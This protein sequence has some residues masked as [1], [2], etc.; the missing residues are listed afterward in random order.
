MLTPSG[1]DCSLYYEDFARGVGKQECRARQTS[2][3]AEWR[4]ADCARCPVPE[5][6]MANGSRHLELQLVIH[7]GVLGIGRRVGVEA[8]CSLH[9]VALTDPRLGCDQCNREADDLLERAFRG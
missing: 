1:R 4:P 7:R 2:G 6:L 8:Y 3:S 5:I 9:R